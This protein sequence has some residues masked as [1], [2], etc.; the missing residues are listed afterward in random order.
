MGFVSKIP[1]SKELNILYSNK[2]LLLTESSVILCY[3]WN[4]SISIDDMI[5]I[6]YNGFGDYVIAVVYLP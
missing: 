1:I 5:H 2:P 3:R 6:Y 4:I